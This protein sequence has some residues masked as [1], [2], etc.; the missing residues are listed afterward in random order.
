[1]KLYD[2]RRVLVLS[3]FGGI[4]FSL[5]VNGALNTVSHIQYLWVCLVGFLM[6]FF[7]L[8]VRVH[9]RNVRRNNPPGLGSN[10]P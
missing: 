8:C 4:I 7:P 2:L 3:L 5:T 9:N 10:Y 6:V 1:M